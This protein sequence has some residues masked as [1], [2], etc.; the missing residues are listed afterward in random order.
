MQLG[1]KTQLRL[2]LGLGAEEGPGWGW[3][4]WEGPAVGPGRPGGVSGLWAGSGPVPGSAVGGVGA[5]GVAEAGRALPRGA[6]RALGS[7]RRGGCLAGRPQTRRTPRWPNLPHLLPPRAWQDPAR[8]LWLRPV[9]WRTWR[10]RLRGPAW[11]ACELGTGGGTRRGAA[12]KMPFLPE[13]G[14]AGR[15]VALALVLLLPAVPA[16]AGARLRLQP[17]M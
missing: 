7:P 3:R 9:P 17:N 14:A 16:G 13:A 8:H 10:R 4:V 12:G 1:V 15:A 5:G 2:W 6:R 11:A